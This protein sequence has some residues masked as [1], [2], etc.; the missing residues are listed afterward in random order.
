MDRVC[1]C[2]GLESLS[3]SAL[4]L[5]NE[6][7]YQDV[8]RPTAKFL[9]AHPEFS[10]TFSFSGNE[11]QFLKKKHPE[12]L[13][14][15]QQLV[16]RKQIEVLGGGFYQP[17]FPMLYAKDR[18]D[19]VELLSV[20]LRQTVGK[21]P[22]GMTLYAD[23]WDASLVTS[24][25]TCGMEYVLLDSSLIRPSKLSYLPLIMS[26]KGKNIIVVPVY[27]K[28]KPGIATAEEYL[29]SL[30]SFIKRSVR[31]DAYDVEA[32]ERIVCVQLSHGEF[33]AL[34][35]SE[36]FLQLLHVANEKFSETIRF[37]FPAAYLKM[38][39][40]RVPAFITAGL[41][42]EIAQW[43][44]T[45]YTPAMLK[46]D[47]YPVTIYD[48]LQTYP[49]SQALCSRM[50]YVSMLINQC[51]GDKARKKAAR[52][53]LWASQSG[54]AFVCTA[55]GAFPNALYRQNAY[56]KLNEAEKIVRDCGNF[57]ESTVRFDYNGDGKD[58][59]IFR[60]GAY[61]AC[62]TKNAGALCEFNVLQSFA[63]YADNLS[64]IES[65]DGCNDNYY[66]GLF[67][68]HVFTD[69]DIKNYVQGKPAGSGIF[70][71]VPYSE[72]RFSAQHKEVILAASAE[73][74]EK[75]QLLRLRKKYVAAAASV[76][77]QY[78]LKNESAEPLSAYFA[79][80]L[81]F[82]QANFGAAD[83][84]PYSVE[85]VSGNEKKVVD[86]TTSS[87]SIEQTGCMT[88]VAAVQLS[89]SNNMVSFVVEP[90]E[91]CEFCF[92]PIIFKRPDCSGE[93][94]VPAAMTFSAAFIWNVQLEPGMEM[95]KTVNLSIIST[96]RKRA[97]QKR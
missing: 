40:A 84:V 7:E 17:V 90:N 34:L 92:M 43:A 19:Q 69:R 11:L 49:Q 61:T 46:N 79:A 24:F 53:K 66:R 71:E 89:D 28:H 50:L 76:S 27:R 15:V 56:A 62:I 41:N 54:E 4:L 70:S 64:R 75:R 10:M 60:M 55:N 67:V 20:E 31:G 48:F 95:E 38:Q 13:E 91:A 63:N 37:A 88:D 16:N 8:Y 74:G 22:R 94:N 1:I 83:F 65:F 30:F 80:E 21:R 45:P 9:Y 39:Q 57:E 36:F 5:D 72:Q 12:F 6:K 82:L 78:I 97:K 14:L 52:E 2:F 51:H 58:E 3:D 77:V 42:A 59:Y 32:D 68:D 86:T 96:K 73:F 87:C 44:K 25:Q 33:R 47:G 26:D 18:T 85:I 23:G 93:K 81:N 29:A 35:Q